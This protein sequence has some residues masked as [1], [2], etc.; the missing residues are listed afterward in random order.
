MV[1]YSFLNV[2]YCSEMGFFEPALKICKKKKKPQGLA[3][4]GIDDVTE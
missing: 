4:L 3:Y 1:G 2:F